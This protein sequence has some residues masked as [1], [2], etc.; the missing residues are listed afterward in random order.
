MNA[1]IKSVLFVFLVLSTRLVQF[2]EPKSCVLNMCSEHAFVLWTSSGPFFKSSWAFWG[3]C[4]GWVSNYQ[5][6]HQMLMS[7]EIAQCLHSTLGHLFALH[8][9]LHSSHLRAATSLSLRI[10]LSFL[11]SSVENLLPLLLS[12]SSST[13]LSL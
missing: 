13:G 4:W 10:S 5:I 9:L 6:A 1:S 2:L 12:S 7:S 3:I 8:K 11:L